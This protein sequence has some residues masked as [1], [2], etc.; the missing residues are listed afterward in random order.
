LQKTGWRTEGVLGRPRAL[1]VSGGQLGS[2]MR[3][4]WYATV[5]SMMDELTSATNVFRELYHVATALALALT[6]DGSRS[7]QTIFFTFLAY[8]QSAH[9]VSSDLHLVCVTV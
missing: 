4:V 3:N 6:T 9:A 7:A 8:L 5:L 1:N 2:E